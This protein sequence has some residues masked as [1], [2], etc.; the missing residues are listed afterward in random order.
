MTFAYVVDSGVLAA[1]ALRRDARHKSASRILSLIGTGRLGKCVFTDGVLAETLTLVRFSARGGVEASN[2]MYELLISSKNLEL[3]RL[4]DGEL[5][6]AG[7]LFKKYPGLSFVDA[8]TAALMQG[9]GIKDLL[10]FDCG[11][12]SIPGLAR[13]E[14]TDIRTR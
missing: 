9:R 11:F 5:K 1:A 12:D 8:A 14:E 6:A 4:S 10:S 2:A 3:V 7:E 13:H